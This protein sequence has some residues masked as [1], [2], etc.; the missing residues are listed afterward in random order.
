MKAVVLE[1]INFPV[2]LQDVGLTPLLPG[3]VLVKNIVSGLCGA[4]LHEIKGHKGNAKF[5]PHLMG[6][7]GCGIVKDIGAGVMTVKRGDKVVLHWKKGAGIESPFPQYV[8]NNK[9]ISSGKVITL[10]EYS[11]VSENRTTRVSPDAPERLC[12]L[13]GCGTTTALGIINNDAQLKFGESILIL[14]AGGVGLNLIQGARLASAYPIVCLDINKNKKEKALELG[15]SLFITALE[16]NNK[17]PENFDVIV[18]TL[19]IASVM[20]EAIPRLADGGRYILV[21]QPVPGESLII[22]KASELWSS[23]GKTLK[24][25]QG[26]NTNP[27]VDIPRYIKMYEAGLLDIEK[28]ITHT[29]PL[30][31]IN[32]AFDLLQ[33]GKAGRIIIDI[34]LKHIKEGENKNH[35][36]LD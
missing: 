5:L 16:Q 35:D 17:Q 28:I 26:G 21:G 13:L 24:V 29:F 4:Q 32:A 12:A 15:A 6:H 27:E 2:V 7:E 22:P 9:K 20:E 1:K 23:E 10:S 25:S 18:D 34:D 11:I 31:E 30:E 19:G 8:L 14:G 36:K 33:S 3:Q